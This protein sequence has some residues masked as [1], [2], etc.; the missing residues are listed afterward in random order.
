MEILQSLANGLM[1]G[2]IYALIAVGPTLVFG[3]M[4]TVN[5]APA[6]FLIL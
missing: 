1:I 5:F 4:D 6:A 3:V 2:S